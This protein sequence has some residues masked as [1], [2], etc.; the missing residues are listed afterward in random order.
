MSSNK[1]HSFY[2]SVISIILCIALIITLVPPIVA[3]A[4]SGSWTGGQV[5]GGYRLKIKYS[6]SEQDPKT[7]TSKVTATLYLVQDTNYDLY[8]G[9]RSATITIN[10]AKTTISNIPAIQNTGGVTTKLGSASKTIT[11]T[12][13]G[14]KSIKI[15]A[16]FE[17]KATLT[18]T[19]YG[20]MSTS[21]TVALDKLDRAAPTV[22]V[23]FNSATVSSVNLTATA[24]RICDKW[25]YS[26]NGGSTWVSFGSTGTSNTFTI[27]N[28]T[29]GKTYSVVVRARR[30]L[31]QVTSAKSSAVSATTKP[32]PPQN[33]RVSGITNTNATLSWDAATGANSYKTYLNSSL[34]SSG[35]TQCSYQYTS[36]L[37]NSSYIFGVR[38]VGTSG[39]STLA[40]T[41]SYLTYPSA[42]TGLQVTD[43][44]NGS[45]SLS[46][47]SGDDNTD[48]IIYKVYRDGVDVGNSIQ[49]SYT[50]STYNN[51]DSEYTVSAV[52]SAGESDQST[53]A[54]ALHI[55]LDISLSKVDNLSYS[56]ITPSFTG[57]VGN[58]VDYGSFKWAY[59][60]REV[61]YFEEN[62]YDFTEKFAARLNGTYTV[63]ATDI[64]GN[65]AVAT[66]N[67][68]SIYI[69]KTN[70]AYVERFTDLEVESKGIDI[71]FERTYNSMDTS[72]VFGRGWSLSYAKE[73][74][75]IQ[76]A[77][78]QIVYLPDGTI[79]YFNVTEDGY[80]GIRTQNTLT[81]ASGK[82][83]LET[84]ENIKYT[85]ESGYLTKIE[86][87]NGNV[88]TIQLG[89][90]NLPVKIID[91][92]GREYL[93]SY[94]AGK[95]TS[96]TDPAMRTITYVYDDNGNLIEQR[97]P[98]GRLKGRYSYENGRLSE[99]KDREGNVTS[100]LTYSHGGMMRSMTD[101][102]GETSYY[103]HSVTPLGE[104][105][106]YE[107]EDEEALAVD[108]SLLYSMY[109]SYDMLI[110]DNEG[111]VY[112]Y[113][114]DGSISKIDGLNSDKTLVTY[115][116]DSYG[117]VTNILTKD[118][119]ERVLENSTFTYSYFAGT[120]KVSSCTE[121]TVTYTHDE[122][123]PS[124]AS[125]ETVTITSTFDSRGNLLSERTVQGAED[126]TY[127]YT[128]GTDG[129]VL[130]ETDGEAETLYSYDEYGY[131]SS[132]EETSVGG[133]TKVTTFE[134][135]VIGL[136]LSEESSDLT[137]TTLYDQ[138]ANPIRVITSDGEITRI[139]RAVYDA[140]GRIIQKISDKQ[141]RE[142]D[143]SLRPDSNGICSVNAY[144]N[145]NV[146]ER[147]TYDEKGNILT[148]INCAG[149]LTANTY[150]GEDRLVKTVTYENTQAADSGL[151]TRY[152]YNEDGKLIKTIYP[153]QYF[154]SSDN[155][156]V[157]AGINEYTESIGER[158][159]YDENG[160]ISSYID[161]FGRETV[162]TYDGAGHLVKAVTDGDVTRFVYGGGDN[163]LQVIYPD[164]YNSSD[165]NLDLSA[166]T[167]VDSYSNQNVGERYTYD[168]NG[169]VL[170]YTNPFGDVT[171]NTYDG[172][173][174][175]S[176]TTNPDGSIFT[177]NADGKCTG[178]EYEN[179]MTREIEYSD[180]V[181]TITES[182]GMEITFTMNA[183]GE[184][185][186]HKVLGGDID[187][188]YSYAYDSDGN[189]SKI[190]LN[191]NLQQTFTY[192]ASNELT[193]VDDT[194]IGK[195][196]T[197]EYDYVGNITCV[198]TYD[199]TNGTLSTPVTTQNYTYNGDNQRSDLSYDANGNLSEL[200][201]YT[202]GWTDR[203]L[204]SATSTDNSI[205]YT[206]T[207][208]GIRSSKTV[209]NVTT[210]YEVDQVGNVV[211]QYELVNDEETNVIEF[212]YDSDNAPIYFTYQGEEY[213]YELNL[214]GDII[215]LLDE[216]GDEVVHYVYD[217]WGKV[218]SISGSLAGTI[219]EAN[220]LRYRGYYYD[221]ETE[222]YYL[223]SRYYSPEI[224]RFISPDD[225]VFSN[226][227]GQPLGSNLYAYCLNEPVDSSDPEGTAKTYTG[228]VGFGL[229]ILITA[230]VGCYQGFI[231]VEALWFAFTKNNNFGNGIIPWC[232]WFHGGGIGL[233]VN[234]NK[235][236]SKNFLNNPKNILK[237][238]G[239]NFS[240]SV[241]VTF[242]V[243]TAKKM[244]NPKDYTRYSGFSSATAWGVTI[245][246]ASGGKITTYGIGYTWDVGVR[247]KKGFKKSISL[248]K[249]LFG[250]ASGVAYYKPIKLG[251]NAKKL[252]STVARRVDCQIK[253]V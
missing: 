33:L 183:F 94:S 166:D 133:E 102:A 213:Y 111:L 83:V 103:I 29:G 55:P 101:E 6:E 175:L 132:T 156:D 109:D 119:E 23:K 37:P 187:K 113:G 130:T 180:N 106:I 24:S 62:G 45:V 223:Q 199:L 217:I 69:E 235:L 246:K 107:S 100:S 234:F 209:N 92:V 193:R 148:Y 239:L 224:M 245:S 196:V 118:K 139:T 184:V 15:A 147:Y 34:T 201:D 71:S 195:T 95:I 82:L 243:V 7:N 242:F 131:V 8:I 63:F 202:F 170:T 90:D 10:G 112:E 138:S 228:I 81:A 76:D 219:G 84:K 167:P 4:A 104:L 43:R 151:T 220:P 135:N 25:Q 145:S 222:L 74:R 204:T 233:T 36:L 174:N 38:S 21:K 125:S 165:D 143:D 2:R 56:V 35:I 49:T 172:N 169:K 188:E 110:L 73:T 88:V 27:S 178:E 191:G 157:A 221:S 227:Q 41:E 210:Y 244:T 54:E 53:S 86:D 206:Y 3:D 31:N 19:Y 249:K 190:W 78:L 12:S 218:A 232:Y 66:I 39:D 252:Y 85:Y 141:Y 146:G 189:I 163:L 44:T 17:M 114:E 251:K 65:G 72:N 32:G 177:F 58:E 14:S 164:Q 162:N 57:G 26:T 181:T 52:N 208:N 50:D 153:H 152:V 30:Q 123:N 211:K 137:I 61:A 5:D 161:S 98:G 18:G 134:N 99:V 22:S 77:N 159:I 250:V 253:G 96:I 198:K 75:L 229:Q 216:E 115:T 51:T 168:D 203:R 226:E 171:T 128:Y 70:G 80:T 127:F 40:S 87:A 93:I 212:V 64:D 185:T 122:E 108:E 79:S 214:Q 231:G 11:H 48:G 173:G 129:L 154:A 205:S 42:P 248:G 236:L 150:D 117:N 105:A 186:E 194:V 179:G 160:N 215:S 136:A 144:S 247:I 197:Y 158:A 47:A 28:L 124:N 116:Y 67:I 91:S 1:K 207:N 149:N 140:D 241:G 16:T 240:V 60:G 126:D 20:T 97:G 225:P 121:N 9:T 120:D 192:N 200:N 176:S 13:D 142:S 230:N 89:G 238:F 59:G 68:D 46:W 155:L 182:S 237:G